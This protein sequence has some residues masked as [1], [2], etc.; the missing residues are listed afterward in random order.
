MSKTPLIAFVRWALLIV[1]L[2]VAWHHAHWSVA[3]CLSLLFVI[4]E[5]NTYCNVWQ[6]LAK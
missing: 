3:L 2:W 1:L 6:K 5:I 4:F